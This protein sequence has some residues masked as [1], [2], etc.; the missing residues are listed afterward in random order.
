[1]YENTESKAVHL[2]LNIVKTH[3]NPLF[4]TCTLIQSFVYS[5]MV[6]HG[7]RNMKGIPVA[8]SMKREGTA[9]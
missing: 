5:L 8:K 9:I 3:Y 4:H 6:T 7:R 2:T 1:M